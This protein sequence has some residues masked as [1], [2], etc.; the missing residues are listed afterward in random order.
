MRN[1][2][3]WKVLALA[4]MIAAGLGYSA[5]AEASASKK[6]VMCVK[7]NTGQYFPVVR[8][9]MMVVVDGGNTFEIVLKDGQGEAGV[10]SISFEKHE[11]MIDFSLYKENGEDTPSLDSSKPSWLITSTGKYFRTMD[12]AAVKAKDDSTLF[13][14]ETNNGIEADVT[15]IY[16]MRTDEE[17]VKKIITGFDGQIIAPTAEKLQLM[18]PVSESM[19]ISGCGNATKATVYAMDGKQ[20]LEAPVNGGNATIY[21]GNLKAGVYIVNVGKKSLKFIK[22]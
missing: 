20:V 22:K 1:K 8:V 9:S 10:E 21:V 7:T 18:T 11:E 3:G 17:E 14:I 15:S 16:F 12:V 6:N 4:A 2:Q 5:N 13:D 19:S